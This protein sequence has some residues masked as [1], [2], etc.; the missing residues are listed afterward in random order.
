MGLWDL[1]DNP[2]FGGGGRDGLLKR[3]SVTKLLPRVSRMCLLFVIKTV[4]YSFL[5]PV[6]QIYGFHI[7]A[8]SI[9]ALGLRHLKV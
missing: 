3:Y 8:Q 5:R 2:V 4:S 9:A 6:S 1:G 7:H